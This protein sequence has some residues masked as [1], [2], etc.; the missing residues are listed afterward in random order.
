MSSSDKYAGPE[1]VLFSEELPDENRVLN[2]KKEEARHASRSLRVTTGRTVWVA[3]GKG[4]RYRGQVTEVSKNSMTIQVVDVETP[5][6][7]PEMNLW[8][9]SGV[10][11]STR[12]DTVVEK[13]SELG[14]AR[15]SP[16]VLE[17]GVARPDQ[18]GSKVDRWRRLAV[19]SLKQC[20]RAYL[21][22]IDNPGS[23]EE[24]TARIPAGARIWLA[25]P[26]GIDPL[27]AP[28]PGAP[29]PLVLVAGPEG[30]VS[31][32]EKGLLVGQGAALIG[33]GSH[34]LRAETAALSMV[35]GALIRGRALGP[36]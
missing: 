34:R 4:H 30:G 32:E 23:L 5:A 31:E 16:L 36:G 26:G 10:L 25:D 9:A 17:R 3:D 2:L 21:M 11:K 24:L 19:E 20:R 8:L 15:W 12:T 27:E 18:G 14:V 13:A 6:P 29:H 7:W 22:E 35:M 28:L 33:L 1:H